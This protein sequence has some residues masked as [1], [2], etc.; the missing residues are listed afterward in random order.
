MY[1]GVS[2]IHEKRAYLKKQHKICILCTSNCFLLMQNLVS[3]R[4]VHLKAVYL[5]ALQYP[6]VYQLSNTVVAQ[7]SVLVLLFGLAMLNSAI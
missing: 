6:T 2:K 4:S 5:E 7:K 3:A 1:C